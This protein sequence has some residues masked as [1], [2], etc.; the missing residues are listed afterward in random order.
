MVDS[1][2]SIAAHFG[3]VCYA[4]PFLP[5]TDDTAV[6]ASVLSRAMG[7]LAQSAN[8]Q[9]GGL[10]LDR[11]R[12]RREQPMQAYRMAEARVRSHYRSGNA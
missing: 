4:D 11:S 10:G 3:A 9:L 8:R 2:K 12:N 6:E 1:V 5:S 7:W